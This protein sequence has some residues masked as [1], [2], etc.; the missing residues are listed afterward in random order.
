M[1]D[2]K[3][4]TLFGGLERRLTVYLRVNHRRDPAH[5]SGGSG[6]AKISEKQG[7]HHI[8]AER[9]RGQQQLTEINCSHLYEGDV[10]V[11]GSSTFASIARG[12]HT[13]ASGGSNSQENA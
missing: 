6:S 10:R 8:A 1:V 3:V 13:R 5:A 7:Q 12:V 4:S 9:A 11:K 2:D